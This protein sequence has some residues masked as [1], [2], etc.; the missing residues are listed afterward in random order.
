MNIRPRKVEHIVILDFLDPMAAQQEEPFWYKHQTEY[1][2]GDKKIRE[3]NFNSKKLGVSSKQLETLKKRVSKVLESAPFCYTDVEGQPE[4]V[5][6]N[7]R[8]GS[9]ISYMGKD[10]QKFLQKVMNMN[11]KRES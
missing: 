1:F 5:D 10:R 8:G 11:E 6:F 2:I 9:T 3:T 7:V 4:W